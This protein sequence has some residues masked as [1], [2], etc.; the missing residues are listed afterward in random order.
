[1]EETKKKTK[2][3]DVVLHIAD[4]STE[5]L[6]ESRITTILNKYCKFLPVEIKFGTKTEKI[7]DPKGKKDDKGEVIKIDKVSDNIINN[8]SPA[9][10]KTPSNL[11]DEHYKSFYRELYPMEFSEPLFH[12]HLNVDFP[13][14][15]TGILYFPK[16][17]KQPRSSEK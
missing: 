14:N 16:L 4:D 9:W 7:D 11:N 15:L 1:M 6:E 8:T 13:F 17:K 3:T 2:G 10:T 5:F 12:I